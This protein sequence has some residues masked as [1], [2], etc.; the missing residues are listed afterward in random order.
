[1]ASLLIQAL[2]RA[3]FVVTLASHMRSYDGVG[4]PAR[5]LRIRHL[6]RLLAA[7]LL[8]Q[9]ALHGNTP[10][11]WFTYHLY[12]KAPDWI[13]PRVARA[14]GIPYIVA[15]ASFAPKQASGN[16][17]NN[18]LAVAECLY[19]ADL[20]VHLNPDDE[21]C[22]KPLLKAG[23]SSL[24]LPPFMDLAPIPAP[25]TR[26]KSRHQLAQTLGLDSTS[27]WLVCTAMMRPGDKFSSYRILAHS[28]LPLLDLPWQLLVIG[29][30]KC[31]YQI[32]ELFAAIG[33]R[34]H[35]L[36]QLDHGPVLNILNASDL[37]LWP[38][39]NEA[40]GLSLLEA[41]ACG[42]PAVTGRRPGP[43]AIVKHQYSGLL[44]A[45]GDRE[46]FSSAC[47]KILTNPALRQQFSSHARNKIIQQHSL[48]QAVSNLAA[49][50]HRLPQSPQSL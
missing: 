9:Y 37:Y 15:E 3:D 5:Q 31:R 47:R 49:A 19:Q 50:I 30:G 43:A 7:R 41:Q 23:S 20:V 36:G 6:G 46:A 21:C 24:R 28:L 10:S 44:T 14:L 16:W 26:N 34:C 38:G 13:G 32:R 18:H 27:P 8:R 39:I 33:Q 40:Y 29:D 2:R 1:M 22:V 4:N 12:H 48:Q 17:A 35:W 42:L 11:Y 25:E 45:E